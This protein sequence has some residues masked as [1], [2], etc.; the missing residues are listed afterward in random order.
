MSMPAVRAATAIAIG[1]AAFLPAGP[2]SA[3]VEYPWCLIT[4]GRE[5][6]VMSCGYVSYAQCMMTRLGAEM[7]V[8][9]PRYQGPAQAEPARP[10]RPASSTPR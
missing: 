1:V 3:E 5:D 10:R 4:S 2:A 8:Q 9:N 7:C 6:G